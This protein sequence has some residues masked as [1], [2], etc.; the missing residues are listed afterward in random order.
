MVSFGAGSGATEMSCK[1][2]CLC[3]DKDKRAI[4]AGIINL[5]GDW[6]GNKNGVFHSYYDF[7]KGVYLIL[8]MLKQKYP[9]LM[10]EVLFQ[11]PNP[12]KK[13]NVKAPYYIVGKDCVAAICDGHI[14]AIHFVY[15]VKHGKKCWNKTDLLGTFLL[16]VPNNQKHNI[17]ISEETSISDIFESEV[18]H[19][20]FGSVQ[21]KGWAKMKNGMEYTMY[22]TKLQNK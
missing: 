10:I 17:A 4:H 16:K 3:L 6:K 18:K 14:N 2:P 8:K 13:D 15:D 9:F 11:H 21:R 5:K 12:S 1:Y 20:I 22:I 7:G 19:P